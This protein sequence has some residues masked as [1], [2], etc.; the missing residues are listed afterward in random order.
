MEE[1]AVF[2]E[3]TNNY[4]I[5]DSAGRHIYI[6]WTPLMERN[7]Y[8]DDINPFLTPEGADVRFD[9]HTAP[10]TLDILRRTCYLWFDWTEPLDDLKQRM[11]TL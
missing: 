1:C 6:N 11:M 10:V 5:H 8:R 2:A 9:E 4:C 3:Q 7:A